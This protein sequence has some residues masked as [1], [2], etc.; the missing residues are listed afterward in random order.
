MEEDITLSKLQDQL[1]LARRR[2]G[3]FKK[4]LPCCTCGEA[5]DFYEQEL[6]ALAAK[7]DQANEQKFG[8]AYL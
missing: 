5:L 4:E 3:I 1:V 7:I 6:A 2:V 8:H